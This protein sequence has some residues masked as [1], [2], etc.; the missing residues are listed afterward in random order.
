[1]NMKS[2]YCLII[3]GIIFFSSCSKVSQTNDPVPEHD[4]FT[5]Q[6]KQ[7]GEKRTINVWTP[8]DYKTSL[9]DLPVMYMADGGIEEDFPHIANTLEKL[10]E[11]G[12]IEPLILVGIENTERRRDL[13]GFTEVAE[14]K[15]I[16]PVVGGSEKFRAFIKD[17]LFSE[18]D[19]RYRITNEKSIIGESLSGLFVMETFFMS[20]DMFDNYI[21]FDPS[22]WWNDH[23]LIKTAKEHLMKFP[24]TEKRVWFAGSNAADISPYTQEAAHIFKVE[25]LSNVKWFYS[26]EPKEEHH[27]IFRATKEKGIIWTLSKAN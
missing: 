17:E 23:Y 15:E 9:D 14:D 7:I 1:M 22:L 21:A 16:A 5:I 27:T 12:K 13:T 26:D 4:T 6:S 8:A 25:N 2:I 24:T 19:K 3:T 20:P 11:E 18:I 10:I